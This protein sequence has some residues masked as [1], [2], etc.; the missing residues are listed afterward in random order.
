M[1]LGWIGATSAFGSV[2]R[3][4]KRSATY[5]AQVHLRDGD[6]RIFTRNGHDWTARFGRLAERLRGLTLES[7]ILDGE[8][9]A[10]TRI[11]RWLV[12]WLIDR[13]M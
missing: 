8:I 7:L 3:N 1:A 10:Q 2:V 6:A 9:A 12:R 13:Q 11:I 4:P 5:R